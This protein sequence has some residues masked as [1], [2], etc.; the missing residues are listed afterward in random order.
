MADE[1]ETEE[2]EF[3]ISLRKVVDL[4]RTRRASAAVSQVRAF[5]VRHMKVKPENVWIDGRISEYIWAR[6]IKKA[7]SKITVK[8]VKFEDG[9]VEVSFPEE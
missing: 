2:S 5:I 9:L 6:S 8:A 7:P 1:A 4:P 3:N